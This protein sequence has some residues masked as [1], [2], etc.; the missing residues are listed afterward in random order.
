MVQPI[1]PPGTKRL[2][3][4]TVRPP[5]AAA[6]SAAITASSLAW[7]IGPAAGTDLPALRRLLHRVHFDTR[8]LRA[9]CFLIA[10]AGDGPI[11][12]CAQIKSVSRQRVLGSV[13]VAPAYRRQ[14]IGTALIRALL[15]PESGPVMLMCVRE[16][17]PYYAAFG[18]Q[19]VS[20]RQAP[21]GVYWRWAV[22]NALALPG[23][24]HLTVMV[25]W[26]PAPG[27]AE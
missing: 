11:L 9:E 7:A 15:A 2:P 20:S 13:V 27:Q 17:A 1:A 8:G 10:R 5:A 16:L 3:K 19:P 23:A 14:G 24:H 22:L 12:G 25:M 18:F 26:R 4:L 21:F 6:P